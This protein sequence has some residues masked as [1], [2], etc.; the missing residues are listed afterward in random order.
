MYATPVLVRNIEDG[1]ARAGTGAAGPPR[2]LVQRL[3]S[4]CS[5]PAERLLFVHGAEEAAPRK[6]LRLLEQ[7][8]TGPQPRGFGV[9]IGGVGPSAADS[10][11][12]EPW[13][14]R[15]R[16]QPAPRRLM[17]EVEEVEGSGSSS[18]SSSSSSSDGE[19]DYGSGR[20]PMRAGSRAASHARLAQVAS[21]NSE[22]LD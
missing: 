15:R 20:A 19:G 2:T 1:N 6:L 4:G 9:G 21:F 3:R 12:G 13:A 14:E 8:T 17:L 10:G 11:V 7:A 5:Q 16:R 18:S 22:E